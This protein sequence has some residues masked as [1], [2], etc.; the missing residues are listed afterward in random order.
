MKFP[1][2]RS[3]ESIKNLATYRGI[4][5]GLKQAE[6]FELVHKIIS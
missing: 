2:P 5:S 3:I 4:Q 1:H 6:A